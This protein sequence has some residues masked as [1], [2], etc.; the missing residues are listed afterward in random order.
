ERC[1][2][3]EPFEHFTAY[4]LTARGH[5]SR[6]VLARNAIRSKLVERLKR[7]YSRNVTS[8]PSVRRN[9]C[10][11]SVDR[12]GARGF[13]AQAAPFE[14]STRAC[15]AHAS[16]SPLTEKLTGNFA[17]FGPLRVDSGARRAS[18]FNSF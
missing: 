15:S 3:G 14:M 10:A 7:P 2:F 5:L 18:K 6:T 13:F 8:M 12:A 1:T 16:N 4:L 17:E 11:A 9:V